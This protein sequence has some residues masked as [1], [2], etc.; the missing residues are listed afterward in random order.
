MRRAAPHVLVALLGALIGALTVLAAS[1][2]R[3]TLDPPPADRG[4]ARVSPAPAPSLRSPA[5]PRSWLA[6]ARGGLPAHAERMLERMHGVMRATT[7]YSGLDWIRKTTGPDGTVVDSPGAGLAIPLEVLVVDPAGYARFVPPSERDLVQSLAPG[8]VLLANTSARLR[9]GGEGMEIDVGRRVLR[10]TGVISDVAANGYEAIVPGPVPPEWARADRFVLF[11]A[12]AGL[13][14][15]AVGRRLYAL[16]RPEAVRVSSE[17]ETPFLRYGDA[18]LPQMLI[19]DAFG[20]WAGRPLP[21]GSLHI[22]P[23]WQRRNIVA[24]RVPLLGRAL[25]HRALMAQLRGALRRVV[26]EGLAFAVDPGDFG[27]CFSAHFT[28]GD[29]S[30][31]PS[32][33]AWGIAADINVQDNPFGV[34]PSMHPRLVAIFEDDWGFTWGGRWM[35]PDGMHFEWRRWP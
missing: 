7:V 14:R 26:S 17:G 13:R 32:H 20:E 4:P 22:D 34:E 10:V 1:L 3:P 2:G 11:H 23:A 31:R 6:W 9:D 25:C 24:H 29:P 12:G 28:G 30:G 8:Q 5:G 19:K 35:T 18:V 27:G 16:T 15:G 33:H 21:D